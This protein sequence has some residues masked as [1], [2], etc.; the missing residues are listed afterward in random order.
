MIERIAQ[1]EKENAQLRERQQELL[2]TIVKLTNELP[3]PD[4]VRGWTAQR[5]KLVAEIGTLRA[6]VAQ[7]EGAQVKPIR[8]TA[9]DHVGNR[10]GYIIDLGPD[11]PEIRT[12]DQGKCEAD[13]TASLDVLAEH[14]PVC[15]EHDDEEC[16]GVRET[17]LLRV[18][19]ADG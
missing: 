16:D 2:A 3:Y 10:E 9:V 8:L 19:F 17:L 18:E 1:L 4:E 11:G 15:L 7:L 6:K 5:A 13:R 14:C 12:A